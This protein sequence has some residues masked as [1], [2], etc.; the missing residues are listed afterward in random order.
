MIIIAVT[1]DTGYRSNAIQ[2]A[3][4]LFWLY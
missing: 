1:C 3:Q 4:T 2:H